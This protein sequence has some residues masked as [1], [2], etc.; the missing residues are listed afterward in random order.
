M[1]GKESKLTIRIEPNKREVTSDDI[2]SYIFYRFRSTELKSKDQK[3]YAVIA[4]QLVMMAAKKPHLLDSRHEE[5]AKQFD[6][7][8]R[9]Y[10]IIMS[11]LRTIGL[12]RKEGHIYYAD[13]KFARFLRQAGMT[14][15]LFC[16]D[17]GIPIE[18]GK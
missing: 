10:Q 4:K 13:R 1:R 5:L 12:M 3:N 9:E 7:T 2:F 17:L 6:I 14:I 16:D 18:E 15:S 11:K 8:V